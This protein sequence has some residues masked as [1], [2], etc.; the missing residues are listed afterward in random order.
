MENDFVNN[1]NDFNKLAQ[2]FTSKEKTKYSKN[3]KWI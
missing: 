2:M 1:E 3:H